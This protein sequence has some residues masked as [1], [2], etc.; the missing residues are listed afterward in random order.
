[1]RC[2]TKNRSLPLEF[3]EATPAQLTE[4][5][6]I[7]R[8]SFAYPWTAEQFLAELTKPYA[9]TLVVYLQQEPTSVLVGY[10]VYWLVGPELHLLNLAVAPAW[11]RQGIGRALLTEALRRGREAGAEIAWLEVRPSNT[12]ALA[13]YHSLGFRQVMVRK[14]YYESGEDALILMLSLTPETG[15]QT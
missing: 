2:S 6:A 4:L 5:L 9:H 13:L 3:Q 12:A 7:E 1:M 14:R 8:A 15:C 10:A 11:R